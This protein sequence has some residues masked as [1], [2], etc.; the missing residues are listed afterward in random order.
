MLPPLMV[1]CPAVE[2]SDCVTKLTR[3][4]KVI[5]ALASV[6]LPY[7]SVS[8]LLSLPLAA[9]RVMLS[10]DWLMSVCAWLP[11]ILPETVVSI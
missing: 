9:D 8:V 11:S 10:S 6:V 4:L 2:R 5:W 3:P 7:L 1:V